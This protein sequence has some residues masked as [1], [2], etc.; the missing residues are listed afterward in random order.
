LVNDVDGSA[1]FGDK[2]VGCKFGVSVLRTMMSLS[3]VLE[4]T[5]EISGL[6][7]SFCQK[8]RSPA[9]RFWNWLAMIA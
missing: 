1:A 6:N 7:P 2:D 9:R 3:R 5:K 8:N 4:M